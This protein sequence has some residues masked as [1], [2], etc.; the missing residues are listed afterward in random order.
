VPAAVDGLGDA[1]V[2]SAAYYYPTGVALD[3][4]GGR[5]SPAWAALVGAPGSRPRPRSFVSVAAAGLR[6]LLHLGDIDVS[7]A[8]VRAAAGRGLAV[9]YLAAIGRHPQALGV[10]GTAPDLA[11]LSARAPGDRAGVGRALTSGRNWCAGHRGG[12]G[13]TVSVTD[14]TAA[15]VWV[16]GQFLWRGMK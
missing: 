1:V 11:R 2:V 13:V 7:E 10:G 12:F 15:N 8:D 4:R 6:A 16:G 5:P 9:G 14:V 3:R